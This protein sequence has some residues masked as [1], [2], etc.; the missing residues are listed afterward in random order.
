MKFG[1]IDGASVKQKYLANGK[2]DALEQNEKQKE[3]QEWM[4]EKG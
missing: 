3:T 1:G 2:K 4:E